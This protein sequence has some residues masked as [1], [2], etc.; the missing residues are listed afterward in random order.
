MCLVGGII[1]TRAWFIISKPKGNACF[2]IYVPSYRIC[3]FVIFQTGEWR[4]QCFSHLLWFRLSSR[5]TRNTIKRDTISHQN[6]KRHNTR[7]N[8]KIYPPE[9]SWLFMSS[10]QGIPIFDSLSHGF[11]SLQHV[12][13]GAKSFSH[14]M[15]RV[16]ELGFNSLLNNTTVLSMVS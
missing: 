16:I 12:C 15:P 6:Q 1:E 4:I 9:M 7:R 14:K 11:I 5:L 13:E 10:L 2:L 3:T 8:W